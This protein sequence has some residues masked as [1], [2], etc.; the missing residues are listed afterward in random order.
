MWN[1]GQV[2]YILYPVVGVGDCE[3]TCPAVALLLYC[4]G[5]ACKRCAGSE[6]VVDEQNMFALKFSGIYKRENTLYI[7]PTLIAVLVGLRLVALLADNS[8]L[9]HWDAGCA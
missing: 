1:A 2:S 6:Y 5:A 8:I 7:L 9:Y 4:F 3:D